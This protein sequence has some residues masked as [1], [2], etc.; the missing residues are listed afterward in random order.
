MCNNATVGVHTDACWWG[1]D[2]TDPVLC[3]TIERRM[4][5]LYGGRRWW[6]V[7]VPCWH[8]HTCWNQTGRIQTKTK[9][10]KGTPKT[11][12]NKD[13]IQTRQTQQTGERP[14]RKFRWQQ[15]QQQRR[16]KRKRKP[17]VLQRVHI[18]FKIKI[19]S[20]RTWSSVQQITFR[21]F[22]HTGRDRRETAPSVVRSADVCSFAPPTASHGSLPSMATPWIVTTSTSE[23]SIL[24]HGDWEN[25]GFFFVVP[26][27]FLFDFVFFFWNT[28]VPGLHWMRCHLCKR[29]LLSCV[30]RQSCR[31]GSMFCTICHSHRVLPGSASWTTPN[32][33]N[34][35][36]TARNGFETK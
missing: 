19:G 28:R 1:V 9:Q 6:N 12:G 32:L 30:Q 26:P 31:N 5:H 8:P 36:K 2:A 22:F 14:W 16:R 17:F 21:L 25:Q 20:H 34:V 24:A 35:V 4:P 33:P 7:H 18:T 11:T 15:Q 29:K 3:C 23:S 27:F 10:K 13:Q